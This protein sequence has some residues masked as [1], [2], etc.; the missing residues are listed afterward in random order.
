MNIKSKILTGLSWTAG[1]SL[2][3]QLITWSITLIVMRLLSPP[4]YG[5]L[6]MASV[7]VA[8]L[9]M[10]ASAGL[11]PAI[12]QAATIDDSQLQQLQGL[13]TGLNFALSLG[14]FIAAPA[15]AGFFNE[16]RLTDIIRVLSFQ[17]IISGFS[18]IPDSLLGRELN[19]KS[20]A[21]V[22]LS[23][24]VLGGVVTL[25]F[26]LA[27]FGVWSLIAGAMVTTT[28]KAIFLNLLSPHF[29]WPRFK[30]RGNRQ[31]LGYGGK[32]TAARLLWFFYSQADIFIAGKLL[33]K[34]ALGAYSVSM[35]LASLPVQK[36]SAVNNQVAF[37]AFAKIQN[38]RDLV[39]RT[40][41]QAATI[42]SFFSFP[43]LWGLSGTAPEIVNIVLGPKWGSAVLPLQ[44]LP[45]IMPLRM[46]SGFVY[47]ALDAYGRPDIG[48]KNLIAACVVMP[49]AFII[50]S[51]WGVQGVCTAWI[52]CYP[53]LVY[54]NI[55]RAMPIIGLSAHQLISTM[56]RPVAA[57]IVMYGA[58]YFSRIHFFPEIASVTKLIF[59]VL[60][61]CLVY[62]CLALT[63]NRR[64]CQIVFATLRKT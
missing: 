60:I 56:I 55:R 26:A 37:P 25:I 43:V 62:G 12:V 2:A 58:I 3:G 6:A 5:L 45:F 22:D 8:F 53:V 21:I 46:I 9:A 40:F 19:F 50:G 34:D 36:I 18:I 30:M 54:A 13:I 59:L 23:A 20:R 10:M 29:F 57:S 51:S 61:G 11:G 63:T 48:I 52:V 7:F 15:I 31:L 41:L 14:L 49:T 44:M 4:D 27:Y 47:S 35:H 24:N 38:D 39:G 1:A 16:A 32:I 64:A 42:L 33:G 28:I 17:F